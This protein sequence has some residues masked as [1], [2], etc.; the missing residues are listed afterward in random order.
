MPHSSIFLLVNSE[1]KQGIQIH[2]QEMKIRLKNERENVIQILNLPV[3]RNYRK[4][5]LLLAL[6]TNEIKQERRKIETTEQ[7]DQNGNVKI[8]PKTETQTLHAHRKL[9]W[10]NK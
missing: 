5:V 3:F 8:G 1:I 6:H 2:I 10:Q 4:Q 7:S 9:I